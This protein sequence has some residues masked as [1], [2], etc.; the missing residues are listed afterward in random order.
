MGWKGEREN[1]KKEGRIDGGGVLDEMNS[2]E[3]GRK[4]KEEI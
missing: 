4:R 1:N 3:R 2:W